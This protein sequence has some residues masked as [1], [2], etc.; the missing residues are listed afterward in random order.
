MN[1]FFTS[2][3]AITTLFLSGNKYPE[4]NEYYYTNPE[5]SLPSTDHWGVDRLKSDIQNVKVSYVC[6]VQYEGKWEEATYKDEVV[7]PA[8][9]HDIVMVFNKNGKLKEHLDDRGIVTERFY[10][11]SNLYSGFRVSGSLMA[12]ESFDFAEFNDQDLPT[13]AERWNEYKT[14]IEEIHLEYDAQGR[15]VKITK[16]TSKKNIATIDTYTYNSE[17][18]PDTY[19]HNDKT[20]PD[21]NNTVTYE[22][23]EMDSEGNW[24]TRIAKNSNDVNCDYLEKREITYHHEL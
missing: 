16:L 24:L 9:L 4:A 23:T 18:F 5:K 22:Y 2:L 13:Y 14:L 17:G 19:T 15:C 1:L 11:R 3:L 8:T 20:Y 21:L 12:T 7:K 10:A 6:A